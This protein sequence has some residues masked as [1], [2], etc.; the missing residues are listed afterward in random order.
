MN[1]TSFLQLSTQHPLHPLHPPIPHVYGYNITVSHT[2]KQ[3]QTSFP[4]INNSY[5]TQS[6]TYISKYSLPSHVTISSFDKLLTVLLDK[7]IQINTKVTF[8]FYLKL[9]T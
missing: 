4:H 5:I 3:I 7:Q 9:D 6:S 2:H 8:K 1:Y